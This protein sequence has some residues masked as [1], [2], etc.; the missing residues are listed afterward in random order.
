MVETY[1]TII[2]DQMAS[3]EALKVA[4][5]YEKIHDYG[6]SNQHLVPKPIITM[7]AYA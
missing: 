6:N 3:D 7:L 2:G 1:T 4:H 5:Y